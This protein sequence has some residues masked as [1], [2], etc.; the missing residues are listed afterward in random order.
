M[1]ASCFTCVP[2]AH[3]TPNMITLC[4]LWN[5]NP[6]NTDTHATTGT[7]RAFH[8]SVT[9]ACAHRRSRKTRVSSTKARVYMTPSCGPTQPRPPACRCTPNTKWQLA[10]SPIHRPCF[11]P[12]STRLRSRAK[13]R[14][15]CRRMLTRDRRLVVEGF[16]L[17]DGDAWTYEVARQTLFALPA[18]HCGRHAHGTCVRAV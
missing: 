11:P 5:Y 15:S 13:R 14:Y 9:R 18:A 12:A 6:D 8:G 7:A 16:R 2:R 1:S 4:R 17:E 10:R 3:F